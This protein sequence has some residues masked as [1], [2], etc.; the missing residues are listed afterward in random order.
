MQQVFVNVYVKSCGDKRMR[1]GETYS[2]VQF[3]SLLLNGL[4][5]E[6]ECGYE[7]FGLAALESSG[8]GVD[9]VEDDVCEPAEEC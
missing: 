5:D 9:G 6:G 2:S 4:P 8:D 7:R 3:F 1:E